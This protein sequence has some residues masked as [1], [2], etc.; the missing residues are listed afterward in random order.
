[1]YSNDTINQFIELRAE[2][3][4]YRTIAQ[5][6]GISIAV[7]SKWAHQ[8]DGEIR[9]RAF[10]RAE[11]LREQYV[12]SYEHKLADLAGELRSIDEELKLR[13]FET[14]STEF[15]LYRKTCLQARLEKLGALPAADLNPPVADLP[16]REQE[17]NKSEQR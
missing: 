15:L 17:V 4:S 10:V 2:G 6:L 9:Q 14:V 3:Q 8:H 16:E 1:M 5:K 11:A 7:A 13:H 12:G